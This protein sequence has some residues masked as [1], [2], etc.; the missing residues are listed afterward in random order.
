MNNPRNVSEIID[1]QKVSWLQ[2]RVV[3]LGIL[4][5]CL[6]GFDNQSIGFVAPA[7]KTAWHL[8]GGALGPVFSAGVLGLGIGGMLIGPYADRFGRTRVLIITVTFTAVM[9]FSLTRAANLSELMVLR[10]LIGL[11]LGSAMPL[12][13]VLANEYAPH[14]RR[15]IMVTLVTCGY[16]IGAASGGFV[17]AHLVPLFGWQSVFYVGGAGTLLSVLALCLWMPESIRFLTL[18]SEAAPRVVEIL[19]QI[20]PSLIFESDVKFTTSKASEAADASSMLERLH[21][22]FARNRRIMTLLL[23]FALLMDLIV[24]NFLNNWLPSLLTD[25]GLP[26]TLAL[27]ASTALQFGGFVGVI[28][29]GLLVDRFGY[30][31]VIAGSFAIGGV[32]IASIGLVGDSL[33]G[34]IAT[35][36]VAGIGSIGCNLVLGAFSPT[37]YPTRIRATGSNWAFG[38][39]RL[40]SFMGPLLGGF[41]ISL[42]WSLQDIF[43][44]V[45]VP[46]FLGTACVL[47]MATIVKPPQDSQ[48]RRA[49]VNSRTA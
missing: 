15:G 13:I 46:M 17:A 6:D 29:M 27:R 42:H 5:L 47:A 33:I 40:L 3:I 37:L 22:L 26:G 32:F 28:C 19:H 4:V 24:L 43:Y 10:F 23:W 12:C 2:I 34:L 21:E 39:A 35:I 30:Y 48:K 38:V 44:I 14:R 36:F 49:I 16:S 45:S 25:T 11:G 20:N 1:R 8:H 31:A 9:A 41:V 7:L 18:H